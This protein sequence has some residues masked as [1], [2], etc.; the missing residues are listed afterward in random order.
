MANDRALGSVLLLA[1]VVGLLLYGWLLFFTEWSIVV[2]Q[3]T[4]FLAV[5]TVLLIV[6]WIGYTLALTPMPEPIEAFETLDETEA[7]V[8]SDPSREEQT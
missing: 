4:G 5:A 6:A 3:L 8:E 7:V 1:S 2:L